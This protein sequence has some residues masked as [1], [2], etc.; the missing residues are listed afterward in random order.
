MDSCDGNRLT[1]CCI[2]AKIRRKSQQLQPQHG[3]MQRATA[4]TG[5]WVGALA[6]MPALLFSAAVTAVPMGAA[7]ALASANDN[8]E[9]VLTRWHDYALASI[10][11][12]FSWAVLPA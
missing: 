11:P 1:V 12:Q 10:T 4:M 3:A 9:S 7:D 5:R 8:R 2:F 6:T